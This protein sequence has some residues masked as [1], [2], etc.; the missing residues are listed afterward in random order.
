MF[1]AVLLPSSLSGTTTI[2]TY[3]PFASYQA[4]EAWIA[5]Q[6]TPSNYVT[7]PVWNPMPATPGGPL[8]P[9][10]VSA[11]Q[12]LMVY[13]AVTALGTYG[14]WLYGPYSTVQLAQGAVAAQTSNQQNYSV[15]QVFATP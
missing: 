13:I 5:A 12:Y 3:G 11:G 14:V 7:C 10:T 15:S 1:L 2:I 4:A 6:T 9:A 8:S